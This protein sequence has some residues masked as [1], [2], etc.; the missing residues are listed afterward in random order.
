MLLASITASFLVSVEQ[1]VVM[2]R[3]AAEPR[4]VPILEPFQRRLGIE[5]R[6]ILRVHARYRVP[7]C[8]A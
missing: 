2:F 3:C 5:A 4:D 1:R 6:E 8:I 7:L